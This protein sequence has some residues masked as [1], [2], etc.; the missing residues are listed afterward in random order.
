MVRMIAISACA[1]TFVF[2]ATA[3][4]AEARKARSCAATGM[5]GKKIS[6]KCKATQKCCLNWLMNKGGCVAASDICL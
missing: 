4:D 2:A 1:L 3:G 5:D 6:W